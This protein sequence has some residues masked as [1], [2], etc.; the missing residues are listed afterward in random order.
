MALYYT[1]SAS[2]IYQL[3]MQCTHIVTYPVFFGEAVIRVCV[4]LSHM[5]PELRHW[6]GLEGAQ[7]RLGGHRIQHDVF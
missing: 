7:V 5:V 4:H 1:L 3:I 2:F 6:D